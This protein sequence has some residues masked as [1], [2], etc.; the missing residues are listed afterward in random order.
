MTAD[1]FSIC[2]FT[3]LTTP[4][5]E[6]LDVIA[7]AGIG[8]VGVCQNMIPAG[9]DADRLGRELAR[10]GLEPTICI[11]AD[12]SPLPLVLF[13]GPDEVAA[14][15]RG[16][17]EAIRLFGA[18]G[19]PAV[20]VLTG[21]ARDLP[22][23]EARDTALASLAR[24]AEVAAAA[25]TRLALEPIYRADHLDW[26]L[27]WDL[28]GAL[29]IVDEIGSRAL[30]VLVDA[31]HLWDTDDLHAHIR[32]A[33]GRIAAV[34]V[35]DRGADHRS[36]ADRRVPGTGVIDL[37]GFI[38]ACEDAG[39]GGR[40]DCELFSDDGSLGVADY[41]DSLW[42]RPAGEVVLACL[43]GFQAAFAAAGARHGEVGAS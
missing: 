24:L 15:E 19:A 4:F 18:I 41:P 22:A 25:G 30:G 10:R 27:V 26:S 38:A 2:N 34:H 1:R 23:A 7:A 6:Q 12:L 13:P 33:G 3:L 43:E 29:G 5:E 42:K 21:P 40:Y 36:W 39:F 8:G 35:D 28:P 17:G 11:P 14:R 37:P 31:F 20:T 9:W 32:A 16:L